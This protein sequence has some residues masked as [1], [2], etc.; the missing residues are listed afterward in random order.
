M[1]RKCGKRITIERQ[2][3]N[4]REK[5]RER[6]RVRGGASREKKGGRNV[7]PSQ[8]TSHLTSAWEVKIS[9][10]VY[11][12]LYETNVGY[13]LSPNRGKKI[14]GGFIVER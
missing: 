4:E 5:E 1:V 3:G 6:M 11:S 10:E 8:L 14:S 12:R 7:A 13:L 9:L 2:Q